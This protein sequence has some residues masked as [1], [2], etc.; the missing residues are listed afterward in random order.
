MLDIRNNTIAVDARNT[1]W[2][3]ELGDFIFQP[4]QKYPEKGDLVRNLDSHNFINVVLEVSSI[5]YERG[6]NW[7]LDPAD[8]QYKNM[9]GF[10]F[11]YVVIRSVRFVQVFAKTNV[12][13]YLNGRRSRSFKMQLSDDL[14]SWCPHRSHWKVVEQRVLTRIEP[15]FTQ[16]KLVHEKVVDPKIAEH[17]KSL[18]GVD[19]SW[20]G[21][22]EE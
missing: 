2:R 20:K 9:S 1:A 12:A 19:T 16:Y 18:E 5:M 21:E 7:A 15:M 17:V 4:V 6:V 22:E 13:N 10:M 11:P 8:N 14:Q 3:P